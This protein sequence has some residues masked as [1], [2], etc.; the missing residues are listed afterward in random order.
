MLQ[1]H[2]VCLAQWES[3]GLKCLLCGTY[4]STAGPVFNP[5]S[6]QA[7]FAARYS[8]RTGVLTRLRSSGNQKYFSRCLHEIAFCAPTTLLN[9]VNTCIIFHLSKVHVNRVSRLSG[10]YRLGGTRNKKTSDL[11][12]L[13]FRTKQRSSVWT[14]YVVT[15]GEQGVLHNR[16]SSFLSSMV[17]VVCHPTRPIARA[18]R[19]SS[20]TQPLSGQRSIYARVET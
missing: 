8:R 14:I 11:L 12:A 3:D 19:H 15:L 5:Q 17:F 4:T 7:L 13:C 6:G 2:Q 18:H 16:F 20:L 10:Q 1:Y 9:I